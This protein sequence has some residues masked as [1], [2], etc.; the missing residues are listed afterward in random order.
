MGSEK[1]ILGILA[2]VFGSLGLLLSWIPIINNIAAI[3]GVLSLILGVIA[4]LINRKNKKMLS[5][6]G[7]SI[8]VATIVI[9]LITQ[10]MYGAVADKATKSFNKDV[11]KVSSSSEKDSSLSSDDEFSSSSQTSKQDTKKDFNIGE[12]ASIA[13]V[14][15]TVNKV[16]Y[17][18]GDGDLNTPDSGK[19]YVLVDL[20][21][22]NGSHSDYEYNPLD[23]QL[24]NNG[25]KTDY[26]E[27]DSD[28]VPNAFD[29]G[30]LSPDAS[31]HAVWVGQSSNN[32]SLSFTYKDSLSNTSDFEFKLR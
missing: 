28:F 9:V 26:E 11:Q 5:I 16:S 25:N 18:D 6:I 30:T 8:S 14:E 2:I 7:T 13:G 12:T 31:Y 27:V 22:K 1:K 4:I 24:S 10:S 21:L 17:S 32:G 3:F 23:F 29:M 15:Y 19:Q 20:T